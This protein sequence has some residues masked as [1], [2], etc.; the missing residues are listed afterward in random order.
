LASPELGCRIPVSILIV[1]DFRLRGTD[2]R[3]DLAFVDMEIY[4]SDGLHFQHFRPN[5]ALTIHAV[6]GPWSS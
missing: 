3:D 4:P 1:V 6:R 5:M 2:E